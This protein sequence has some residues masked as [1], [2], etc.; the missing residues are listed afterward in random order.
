MLVSLNGHFKTPVAYY[1]IKSLTAEVRANIMKELLTILYENGITDVRSITFD[2][3]SSNLSMVKQ[4]GANLQNIEKE[5]FFEHPVSKE[6]IFVVPDACHML[7][8]IRNTLS[9]YDLVDKENNRIKW[10]YIEKLVQYQEKEDLHPG[11]KIRCRHINFQKEKMKVKLAAQ[12]FSNGV[13]TGLMFMKDKFSEDFVGVDAT[14]KFCKIMNDVFDF[15]NSRRKFSKNESQNCL[16]KENYKEMEKKVLEYI[17][18][19]QS[20][21]I[22]ENS[23]SDKSIP[24]LQSRRKTG[25]W[26]FIVALKSI[27]QLAR[28]IFE[29]ETMS[30]LLTYKLSQDHLET[31]FSCIR[32]MRGFNNNPTCRQFKSSYKKIVTHVNSIVPDE[33]NCIL[34]DDTAIFKS[35]INDNN[36]NNIDNSID[37]CAEYLHSIFTFEPPDGFPP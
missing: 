10:A 12:T 37:S 32:R 27:L 31:F 28:Y 14:S 26:G 29:Q 18:Y 19:I 6:P 4:L 22:I 9:E 7:K 3:A 16:T 36:N 17:D 2:G 30:Y 33:A 23:K 25:F 24:I 21:K 13:A 5:S 11:T 8:L 20:L 34:Q 1:F 15:L 35:N